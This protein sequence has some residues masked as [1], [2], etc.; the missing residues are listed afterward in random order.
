MTNSII[1]DLLRFPMSSIISVFRIINRLS[2]AGSAVFS[3]LKVVQCL[4]EMQFG[5]LVFIKQTSAELAHLLHIQSGGRVKE[6][7]HI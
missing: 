7:A 1:P 2:R 6:I 4:A 5:V 3:S